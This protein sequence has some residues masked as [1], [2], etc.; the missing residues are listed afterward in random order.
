MDATEAFN[1]LSISEHISDGK[2]DPDVCIAHLK[3]LHALHAMKEDVGYTDGLFDLY[4]SRATNGVDIAHLVN[5]YVDHPRELEETEKIKFALSKIREKRWA[6]FVARAVDRYE[7]WWKSLQGW[8]ALTEDIMSD[9]SAPLYAGFPV[10]SENA[11]GSSE[12]ALP[13]LGMFH[14]LTLDFEVVRVQD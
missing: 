3:L 9:P 14:S 6:L 1:N 11:K 2:L 12:F 10:I 13:P 7:A 8:N 5:T 4:D